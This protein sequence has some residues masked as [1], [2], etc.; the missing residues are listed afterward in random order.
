MLKRHWLS[1]LAYNQLSLLWDDLLL[2]KLKMHLIQNKRR[3]SNKRTFMNSYLRYPYKVQLI[4]LRLTHRRSQSF[5]DKQRWIKRQE[6]TLWNVKQ[7]RLSF[8][9]ISKRSKI[10]FSTYKLM[11]PLKMEE[12]KSHSPLKLVYIETLNQGLIKKGS[13]FCLSL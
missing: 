5:S 2:E 12:E 9:R 3:L 13:T 6:I 10:N 1:L 4:T 11:D 7:N 8:Q